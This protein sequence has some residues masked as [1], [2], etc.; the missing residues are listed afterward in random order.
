FVWNIYESF[1]GVYMFF[2]KG[3]AFLNLTWYSFKI[4]KNFLGNN[5]NRK[6]NKNIEIRNFIFQYMNKIH[7]W[8]GVLIM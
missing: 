8:I 3:L 1:I 7:Q 4:Q 2:K 5:N 6:N